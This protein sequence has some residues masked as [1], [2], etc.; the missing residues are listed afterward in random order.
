MKVLKC[1]RATFAIKNT[2]KE[3]RAY[4]CDSIYTPSVGTRE[5]WKAVA[6]ERSCEAVDFQE[7]DGTVERELTY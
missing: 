2:S 3:N 7:P 1:K 4:T 5:K 6:R